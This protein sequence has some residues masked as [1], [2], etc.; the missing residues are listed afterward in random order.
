MCNAWNHSDDCTCGFGGEGHLGSGG[1]SRPV[2]DVA[3]RGWSTGHARCELGEALTHPLSCPICGEDIFFH[4]NGYGD[5][6]FFDSLGWPWPKHACLSSRAGVL[7]ASTSTSL[8]AIADLRVR[9]TVI[10]LPRD[11]QPAAFAPNLVG[12]TFFGVVLR[13]KPKVVWWARNQSRM[14]QRVEAAAVAIYA[15]TDVVR[16]YAAREAAGGITAGMV[17]QVSCI[18]RMLNDRPALWAEDLVSVEPT[19]ERPGHEA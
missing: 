15:G 11:L 8:R 4:T 14:R 16:V 5:V 3:P 1:W 7:Q 18:Q 9:P 2:E 13:W 12:T 6:V 19:R 17:V 10:R